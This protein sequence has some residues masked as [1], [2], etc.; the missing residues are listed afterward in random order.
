MAKKRRN[1]G[2]WLN[3]QLHERRLAAGLRGNRLRL[4]L[5]EMP[6]PVSTPQNCCRKSALNSPVLFAQELTRDAIIINF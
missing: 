5:T 3:E 2:A 1:D 4:L 6:A